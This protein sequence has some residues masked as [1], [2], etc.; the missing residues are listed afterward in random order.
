MELQHPAAAAAV[1]V[2]EQLRLVAMADMEL[3]L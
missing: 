1:Q 2:A 3:S